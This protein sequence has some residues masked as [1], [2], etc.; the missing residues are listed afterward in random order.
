MN[1]P[2]VSIIIPT[3]NRAHLIG[4]TL[5]SVIKQ[6]YLNWECI[7][8]DDGS[9]DNTI[10]VLKEYTDKDSR[11]QYHHRPK[12]RPKGANAC[13]N[14]GFE[15]SKGE[16]IMFFD[17][18]DLMLNQ[19]VEIQLIDLL[20]GDYDFSVTQTEQFKMPENISRGIR[21]ETLI[22]NNII[23]DFINFKCFWLLQSVLWKKEFLLNNKLKLNEKLY[24]AQ[25]YEF[26]LN[27]FKLKKYSYASNDIVTTHMLLHDSNM[28]NSTTNSIEKIWS[29]A[30]VNHKIVSEFNNE[31]NE[32]TKNSVMSKLVKYYINALREKQVVYSV[33]IW[34]MIIKSSLKIKCSFGF[35]IKC[36]LA[37]IYPITGV[38]Y[39]LTK[40]K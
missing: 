28:S 7:V 20:S 36:S 15:L 40:I 1:N 26:H 32:E 18:D 17:S 25:D 12:E 19:K 37:L 14:Y 10:E 16:Y 2:L 8:V 38:G 6:T 31:I 11:I 24:Q 5:D 4:E 22:S 34:L 39:K 30:Y 23:D 29:N 13:R 21:S 9:T 33:K 3:Y 35:Y 27:V